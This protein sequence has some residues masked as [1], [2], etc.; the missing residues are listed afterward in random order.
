MRGLVGG[1]LCARVVRLDQH[2]VRSGEGCE[3]G[4]KRSA[5]VTVDSVRRDSD[6]TGCIGRSDEKSGHS[7]FYG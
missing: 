7:Q 3:I 4:L 1:G 5:C 6:D 2:G